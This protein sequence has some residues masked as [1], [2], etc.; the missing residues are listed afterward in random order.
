VHVKGDKLL[1]SHAQHGEDQ[2]ILELLDPEAPTY[3]IDVGANDGQSWSNTFA[4]GQIGFNLLLVEP[5]PIY[6]QR[7]S[8]LYAGSDKVLVENVA[9]APIEG[10]TTFY[11]S[12]N[13]AEDELAM[14]SSLNRD[15]VPYEAV[16]AITVRTVPLEQL[17]T[18]YGWP[19]R[20]AF[21]SVDAEGLDLEV[22]RTA[23]LD[24]YRP[25]V[26]CVEEGPNRQSIENYLSTQRY[27]RKTTLGPNG[28]Y[29]G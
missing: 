6:A 25:S 15:A 28:I 3:A 1:R 18:N 4:F 27:Q 2:C 24:R 14:R 19:E 10:E 11:I 7:C 8:D 16:E 29:V 13:L 12:A 22:L 23:G 17:L 21:I 5:M 26:I 20:Y 9:I